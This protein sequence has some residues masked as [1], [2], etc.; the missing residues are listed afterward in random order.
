MQY[1]YFIEDKNY[2]DMIRMNLVLCKMNNQ[3]DSPNTLFHSYKNLVHTLSSIAHKKE[4]MKFQIQDDPYLHRMYNI[5][6]V[7]KKDMAKCMASMWLML[8]DKSFM[9]KMLNKNLMK[10]RSLAYI[11]RKKLM[12]CIKYTIKGIENS[13]CYWNKNLLGINQDKYF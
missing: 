13:Y 2:E 9:D 12:N 4:Y 5:E 6:N 8:M 3:E 11:F 1:M 7:S 10:K